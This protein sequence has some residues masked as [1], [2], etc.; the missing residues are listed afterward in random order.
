MEKVI[1]LITN[2]KRKLENLKIDAIKLNRELD[3]VVTAIK[4]KKNNLFDSV[5][6]NFYV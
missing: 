3:N 4:K 5:K 2:N 1:Y 6:E